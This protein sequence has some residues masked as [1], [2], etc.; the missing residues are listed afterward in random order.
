MSGTK[1]DFPLIRRVHHSVK[2]PPISDIESELRAKLDEFN[3]KKL[4]KP[5]DTIAITAGSRGINKLSTMLRT[6]VEYLKELNTSPFIIPAMGS[7]G[8]GT[9]KGQLQ[10]LTDYGIT[11][12]AVGCPIKASMDVVKIGESEFGT[13]VY[14]DKYASL[15][16][17][18]I[19]INKINSHSEFIGEF[20]SGVSKMCLIG[21]GKHEGAKTYH[22]LIDQY[23][24]PRVSKSLLK[25]VLE[26]TPIVCGVLIVQNINNQPSQL[27]VLRP[28]EFSTKEPVLLKNYKENTEHL[29]FKEVDLLIVD[30]MGK[31][32]FGAGMDTNI[33]GVKEGSSIQVRWVFVRDLTKE[34]HGNS[35][36]VGLAD[37]TT[38]KLVDKIDYDKMYTNALTARRT[39][40]CKLPIFLR[41]DKE[42]MNAIFDMLSEQ[43]RSTFRMIWIKN[44]LELEKIFVSEYF[45]NQIESR[46]NLNF[47]GDAES[48][49]FDEHG[50]LVNSKKYWYENN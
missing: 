1:R 34:S 45:F 48:L 42:V 41:N 37:F 29:P 32:I 26:N 9:T 36:G 11:E 46:D 43:E 19:V 21:L 39:D 49:Q 33:I 2:N 7:H 50:F 13:P 30:E 47:L 14:L 35:Q 23:G 10:I 3:L 44:T 24:W 31:N 25:V 20:E 6:L 38:K 22:R 28:E 18:I 12:E 15:A 5:N 16:D 27:Y 40:S 8:G 4:L 17:K